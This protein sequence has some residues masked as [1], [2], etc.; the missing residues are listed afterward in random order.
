MALGALVRK[1]RPQPKVANHEIK[2]DAAGRLVLPVELTGA[3]MPTA[4]A[5]AFRMLADFAAASRQE[6]STDLHIPEAIVRDRQIVRAFVWDE[7]QLTAAQ[8]MTV[9]MGQGE[10]QGT[11]PADLIQGAGYRAGEAWLQAYLAAWSDRGVSG[12]EG[13]D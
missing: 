6:H 4:E 1:L 3:L 11:F 8:Y 13:A 2:R 12:G 7:V 9:Q 5:E 10:A